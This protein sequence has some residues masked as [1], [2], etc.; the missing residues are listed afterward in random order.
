MNGFL[1]QTN[2]NNLKLENLKELSLSKNRYLNDQVFNLFLEITPNLNKLD[3]S[4]CFLTKTQFSSLKSDNTNIQNPIISLSSAIFTF[5]NVCK[6]IEKHGNRIKSLNL[7]GI[8][9]L[10]KEENILKLLV[11]IENL[12]LNE[13]IAENLNTL[14]LRT[15]CKILNKQNQLDYL[16][17][18]NS[19]QVQDDYSGGNY[20]TS[21]GFDLIFTE[22]FD[23]NNGAQNLCMTLTRLKLKKLYL[24][25]NCYVLC[26][27]SKIMNLRYL[28]LSYCTL[29]C[30]FTNKTQLNIFIKQFSCNLSLLKHLETLILSYCEFLVNDYLIQ[31]ISLALAKLRYLDIRNCSN[32][33]DKS[34]H[35]I[36]KYLSNLEYLDVS[37]CRK[38][39]D[40]G[41]SKNLNEAVLNFENSFSSH[42]SFGYCKCSMCVRML[43]NGV[44]ASRY[45]ANNNFEDGFDDDFKDDEVD[46]VV[47]ES[48]VC[49]KNLKKLKILKLESLNN[50]SDIG[51]INGIN[52]S[53][54]HELDIKLCTNITGSFVVK[55]E[56]L[57]LKVLNLNQCVKFKNENLIELLKYCKSLK[58][59]FASACPAMSNNIIE[60]LRTNRVILN[61]LD[62]SYC[63][64]VNEHYM[65]LYEQFLYNEYCSKDFFIDKRFISKA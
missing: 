39:T 2:L 25:T 10:N 53:Q 44:H 31:K 56:N 17:I 20:S 24:N 13:L 50:I 27:I 29:N 34:M 49:L 57:N 45:L 58:Q 61:I 43:T 32:I 18:N 52:L 28:D 9:L 60:Y 4:Y 23:N 33:N 47:I 16:N 12:C 6:L 35:F 14:K 63:N 15:M 7:T 22:M 41:L 5:E 62:V 64:N 65:D 26:D 51:L 38:L 8:D 21:N 55:D 11:N 36:A 59:L 42:T 1:I 30:S 54:L 37:W 46:G 3:L 48:D 40:Y 19:M